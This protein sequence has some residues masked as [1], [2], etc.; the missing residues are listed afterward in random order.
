MVICIFK[1]IKLDSSIILNSVKVQRG[2][3]CTSKVNFQAQTSFWRIDE[4][5]NK[6]R[7]RQGVSRYLEKLNQ[8]FG[9]PNSKIVG[10]TDDTT[11]N[12]SDE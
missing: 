7:F 11:N 4:I 10:N 6:E 5:S 2:A 12:N 1:K 8:L 3:Q 9:A